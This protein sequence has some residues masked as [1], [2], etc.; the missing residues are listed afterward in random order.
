MRVPAIVV[1]V[2]AR[3]ITE[4][5]I[6]RKSG[7]YD[8]E[9]VTK[10]KIDKLGRL[11]DLIFPLPSSHLR[12]GIQRITNLENCLSLIDLDLSFNEVRH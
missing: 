7:E 4:A 8:C 10:L 2:C 6:I 9:V 12:I 5:L 11:S 3:M 1:A